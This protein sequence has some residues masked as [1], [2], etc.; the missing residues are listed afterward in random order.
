MTDRDFDVIVINAT[1]AFVYLPMIA[2]SPALKV[3]S[4]YDL[5]GEYLWRRAQLQPA[6]LKKLILIHDALMMTRIEKR[7]LATADLILVPS[8]REKDVLLARNDALKV[9]VVP[10]GVDCDTIQPLAPSARR[11]V[12]YVGSMRYYPNVDAVRFFTS[13][14]W[15]LLRE[16][17]P[18]L[19]FRVIGHSPPPEIQRLHGRNGIRIEGGVDS[20]SPYYQRAAVCAVPLRVGGGTRLKI[21]EAL[22]Y[23]RPVVS[24][25]LG[26]EGLDTVDNEHLLVADDPAD[27]AAQITRLLTD[28]MLTSRLCT[29]G[30]RLVEA[31]YAW[32]RIADNLRDVLTT[33]H[34]AR[35]ESQT[36]VWH[37]TQN[38]PDRHDR[39]GR[40]GYATQTPCAVVS[41]FVKPTAGTVTIDAES[42]LADDVPSRTRCSTTAK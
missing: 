2:H 34:D 42:T 14:V 20:V 19:I 33:A 36:E 1:Q 22:A 8:Q 35:A 40:M 13:R 25:T 39:H 37:A 41:E 32:P 38:A 4:L 15:P 24:T 16:R 7:V 28:P 29:A 3:V 23:A 18:R 10:N 5:V 17:F 26:C 6:G 21:L 9:V 12:L 11:E 30:R 31:Q 27:I